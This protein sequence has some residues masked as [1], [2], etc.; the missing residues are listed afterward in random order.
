MRR[1][2]RG[3]GDRRANR[4][5]DNETLRSSSHAAIDGEPVSPMPR[6]PI[7]QTSRTLLKVVVFVVLLGAVVAVDVLWPRAEIPVGAELLHGNFVSGPGLPLSVNSGMAVIAID[8]RRAL[9]VGCERAWVYDPAEGVT[10]HFELPGCLSGASLARLADGRILSVGSGAS[11]SNTL[12]VILD[13]ESQ[14]LVVAG[15]LLAGR[16]QASATPLPDGQVLIAGGTL[17]GATSS[18]ELFDPASGT[19]VAVGDMGRP[20]GDPIALLLDDGR[21]LIAGGDGVSNPENTDELYIP[22]TRRFEPTGPMTGPRQGFTGTVLPEGRVLIAGG[23]EGYDNDGGVVF[24]TRADIYDPTSGTFERTGPMITP[25]FMHIAAAWQGTVLIAGGTTEHGGLAERWTGIGMTNAELF[26]PRTGEFMA[27]AAMI[28]PRIN[29]LST[30]L[31][32]G[33]VLVAGD[34]NPAAHS[35]QGTEGTSTE[36]YR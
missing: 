8:S 18:A 31:T 35:E 24:A 20:R 34:L 19:S 3:T 16:F 11:D 13:P 33:S 10:A 12:V 14:S 15:R 1:G 2:V 6:P 27:T 7:G 17:E 5:S 36:I 21:V 26:D 9:I 29:A 30:T 22:S 25:R 4:F 23:Y 28:R 32:D